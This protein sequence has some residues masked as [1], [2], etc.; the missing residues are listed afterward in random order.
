MSFLRK[1]FNS[2]LELPDPAT[3]KPYILVDIAD[4]TPHRGDVRALR[5]IAKSIAQKQGWEIHHLTDKTPFPTPLQLKFARATKR[6]YEWETNLTQPKSACNRLELS[7]IEHI[8]RAHHHIRTHG[9]PQIALTA[10]EAPIFRD[11]FFNFSSREDTLQ[12][13]YHCTT[14]T[15]IWAEDMAGDLWDHEGIRPYEVR[16]LVAHD[17]EKADFENAST[18]FRTRYNHL[19]EHGPL[20]TAFYCDIAQL[21]QNERDIIEILKNHDKATLVTCG[22]PRTEGLDKIEAFYQENLPPHI[23]FHSFPFSPDNEYNPYMGLVGT[24]QHI[25]RIGYSRSMDSEILTTGKT[26]HVPRA[27]SCAT[28]RSYIQKYFKEISSYGAGETFDSPTLTPVNATEQIA[29]KLY[30]HYQYNQTDSRQSLI[31]QYI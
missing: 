20:I 4:D 1:H 12:A 21:G 6:R 24:A 15:S 16:Y 8:A 19:C 30:E 23:Q 28:A 18:E 2:H 3:V 14:T 10:P 26:I 27:N 25:V 22:A 29:D 31:V 7:S 11:M 17:L 9:A 13:L 5:G